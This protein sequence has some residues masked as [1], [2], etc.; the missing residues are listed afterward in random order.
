MRVCKVIEKTDLMKAQFFQEGL[1]VSLEKMFS[2]TE[3][4]Q[5][6]NLFGIY[7]DENYIYLVSQLLNGGDLLEF[8]AHA[9]EEVTEAV[10]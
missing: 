6:V 4:A 3:M 7:E 1:Q 5:V 9:K 2:Y 10:V 8:V